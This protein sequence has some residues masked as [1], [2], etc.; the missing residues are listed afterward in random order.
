VLLGCRAEKSW[1]D[2]TAPSMKNDADVHL[3]I[4]DDED[5]ERKKPRLE[6]PAEKIVVK[7]SKVANVALRSVL[8]LFVVQTVPNYAQPWQMRPQ[9]SSAGSAFISDTGRR[10]ILTNAHVV[11]NCTTVFVRKPGNPKKWQAEV[12]SLG[13]V[14]DLALIT[15]KDNAFWSPDLISLTFSDVPDLQDS[16]LVAGYPTGGDSLSITK[17]IVSRITMARYAYASNRLLSIQIDAAINP[18]NSGGPAFSSL[19]EGRICGVAFS[20][21]SHADNIGYVIPSPIVKHFLQEY[22]EHGTFRGV[23]ST[24]F[25]C[26]DMENEH[27]RRHFKMEEGV[28][29]SLIYDIDPLSHAAGV[30]KQND[31]LLEVGGV[32]VAD[33]AT[34][35]FRSDERV[36]FSYLFTKM[37]VG[38]E[39]DLKIHRDGQETSVRYPLCIRNNLVPILHGVEC[40][41]EYFIVGGVVFIPLSY[42]F[43]EHAFGNNWR[44]SVPAP[45]LNVLTDYKDH[46]DEQVV[47][48]FQILASPVTT[49]YKFQSMRIEH[50][51]DVQIRNLR[52][53]AD[54]VDS[55][56]EKYMRFSLQGGKC[57]ILESEQAKVES[58]RILDMHAITHDRS[59]TLRLGEAK[60]TRGEGQAVPAAAAVAV[61]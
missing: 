34:V 47:L 39:V 36:E 6:E 18:G 9:R 45:I 59:K 35:E 19:E 43:L 13:Q 56:K 42:P 55:C 23:C 49:G 21:L 44:R 48:L 54:L 37:H 1:S 60:A 22:R 46:S 29:G 28:S 2:M 51:N 3:A 27:L 14:C 11:S 57:V 38:E 53:L 25:R 31:V 8:K 12:V 41:P 40:L 17:G 61:E 24:S 7:I 50:F 15:V 33:D 10:E 58:P 32:K 5:R 4:S 26:Q 16:I 52:Q 20:K 30:L